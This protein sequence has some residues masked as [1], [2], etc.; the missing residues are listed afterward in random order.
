MNTS[1]LSVVLVPLG[2]LALDAVL[3]VC[4]ALKQG[5]LGSLS[6]QKLAGVAEKSVT[7]LIVGLAGTAIQSVLT[8]DL[9][10]GASAIVVALLGTLSVRALADVKDK[11]A[12]LIAGPLG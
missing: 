2:L 3:G 7:P 6:A 11:A 9:Q 8:G 5:G 1:L 12:A 10:T 4:V